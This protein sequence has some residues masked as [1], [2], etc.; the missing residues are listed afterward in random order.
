VRV[1]IILALAAGLLFCTLATFEVPEFLRLIDDTSNDYSLTLVQEAAPAVV[2]SQ[3]P[4]SD[5]G[6]TVAN[7]NVGRGQR[8]ARFQSRGFA[9]SV[10][11]FLHSLC[12]LR[13]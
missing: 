8:V 1:K 11:D 3:A 5:R 2:R 4:R 10:D 13:T 7:T 9:P 12:I 6:P